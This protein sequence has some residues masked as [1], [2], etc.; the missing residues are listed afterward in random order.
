VRGRAVAA[1]AVV[2]LVLAV[3]WADSYLGRL[4][5]DNL[6]NAG[7]HRTHERVPTD[8]GVPYSDVRI[9][10]DGRML[11][12]WWMP[13]DPRAAHADTTVV[14]VHGV[15][16]TMGKVVRLWAANLHGAGYNLLALDLRNHGASPDT[17]DGLVTYG[18]GE[19]A[20]VEAAVFYL[21]KHDADLGIDE[22][23][24]VLY[25]GSMGAATVLDLVG[26]NP[27]AGVIGVIADSS[28]AD[29]G[30]QAR[31]DG[32][33]KGY[34]A[35]LVD[36]VVARMDSIADWPPSLSRPDEALPQV[37][38]PVLLTQCADDQRIT[39]ANFDRLVTVAPAGTQTWIGDCP[40][41]VSPDHHLDGFMQPGYNE[42]VLAFLG[43]L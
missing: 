6:T 10:S 14:L 11:A 28:F 31:L 43:G 32:A 5:H 8:V 40:T 15:G 16:S 27:P 39:R 7:F 30:F 35:W 24:I 13:A 22:E 29:F 4:A 18:E 26:N 25:G 17:P 20:D 9:A 33:K 1:T 42:T 38:V 41:G 3:G 36:L 34:P 19:A 12:G 2:V 21:Q 23:R 37:R